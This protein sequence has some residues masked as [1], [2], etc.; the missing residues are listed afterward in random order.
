M[1]ATK[2]NFHPG[3]GSEGL[4]AELEQSLERLRAEVIDLYYLHRVD[5]DVPLEETMGVMR[6]F[7]DAGRIA[8]VGLSEVSVEQ[9][10]QARSIVPISAV[11]NEFSLAERMHDE[12]LDFCASE[13]I[14]FVPFFPLR[15]DPPGVA[16][17]AEGHGVSPDQ[18]RLA[19]LLRRSEA[20]APIPGTR[21]LE[22]LRM[23]LAALD[24][25]LSPGEFETLS[26]ADLG[27]TEETT[28]P[29]E[30]VNMRADT[31][32][33][34]RRPL[35]PSDRALSATAH[36][37]R[38]RRPSPTFAGS[39]ARAAIL[40]SGPPRSLTPSPQHRSATNR[41]A[42]QLG[43]RRRAAATPA[44]SGTVPEPRP[45]NS[46]WRNPSFR[47]YADYMNESPFQ[48]GLERLEELGRQRRTAIMC[49]EGHPS[50]CH[51]QLIADALLARG[52]SVL[53]LLGDGKITPHALSAHA[54]TADGRV[55][56]PGPARLD[57]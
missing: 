50:R 13:G 5:P 29:G 54:A 10:K 1:V 16:E 55:F 6:E 17:I 36:R 7:L 57:V 42:S 45:D 47:A 4:R 22:H 32:D 43:G 31:G 33:P 21:S 3:G 48:A 30:P 37:G 14:I 8:H 34:H 2:G 39:R 24:I 44:D 20:M 38:R 25:E 26:A 18:V 52:W 41:S 46:A 19:W 11:Q 28:Q 15:G 27:R 49:A 40:S 23:N 53:H 51:R 9:I 56:Y 35:D 12:V